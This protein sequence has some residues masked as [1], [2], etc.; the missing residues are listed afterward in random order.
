[1]A[2]FKVENEYNNQLQLSQNEN[3]WQLTSVTGLNQPPANIATSIIPNFDG[4]RFNSSRLEPRN[5]VITMA[6]KGNVETNRMLLN[7]VIFSKRY[8]KVYYQN[9][10][11]NVYLEGY[12]ESFEYDVFE[13]GVMAQ[14][15]II[16]PD[17]FWRDVETNT[18]VLTPIINLFEF[19]FAIPEEGIPFGEIIANI[20]NIIQN[21]G[22]ANTGAII[23]INSD[24]TVLNP[25]ITNTTTG[26]T[27]LINEELTNNSQII[28][29]TIRGKKSIY[30]DG[31]NI[32]NKLDGSSEWIELVPGDN[33]FSLAANYGL[34][35]MR[36]SV[37]FQN[38]Y[39]GV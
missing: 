37:A 29:S 1:M 6:I 34:D 12:V 39:G 14:I 5:I 24:Y 28:I 13:Q 8:I 20:T 32:I 7:S 18:S 35:H 21:N 22:S 26:Q 17:P 25:S 27:M 4:A 10:T 15:S 23:T 2:I 9:N 33:S 11:L 3:K 38:L 19:P 36:V 16:C 31:I 30:M